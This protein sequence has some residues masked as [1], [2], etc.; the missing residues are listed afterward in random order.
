MFQL[1]FIYLYSNYSIIIYKD[2]FMKNKIKLFSF[3]LPETIKKR[4]DKYRAKVEISLTSIIIQALD[5][6][7]EQKGY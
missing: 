7:L 3:R 5:E 4:V 6:F 2:L 1:I